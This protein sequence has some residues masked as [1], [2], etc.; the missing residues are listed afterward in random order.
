MAHLGNLERVV[1]VKALTTF[2]LSRQVLGV[3][4]PCVMAGAVGERDDGDAFAE[5]EVE[6][7]GYEDDGYEDDLDGDE[8]E[9][10]SDEASDE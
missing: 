3:G 7:D 10:E 6:D 4:S 5:G 9:D 8:T 1:A 2:E